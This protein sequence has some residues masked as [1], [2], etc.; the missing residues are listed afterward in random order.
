MLLLAPEKTGK[1]LA[2]LDALRG[3]AAALVVYEHAVSGLWPELHEASGAWFAAGWCGVMVFFLASGYIVPASLERRGDVRG[4]WIGRLFRLYPLWAVCVAAGLVLLPAEGSALSALAHLTMLQD[5]LGV[6]SVV[7]V[8]WTLSYEMAFYLLLT[9]LFALGLHRRSTALALGFTGCALAAGL[10]GL[11]GITWAAGAEAF[12]RGPV[13]VA[14]VVVVG[15]GLALVL[16]GRGRVRQAGAA[17]LALVVVALLGL[18]GRLPVW[19]SLLILATMF[20]GTVLCRVES[21]QIGRRAAWLMLLIPVAGFALSPGTNLK[22]AFV[23]A[24]VIFLGGMALRGRGMPYALAWLGT[25]S[26]SVYLL[27]PLLLAVLP[28]IWAVPAT[29]AV[30][31]LT[32]RLVE[33]PAQRLGKRLATAGT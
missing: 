33:A 16:A 30:S 31:A 11:A 25:V 14:A 8:L 7:S 21:G 6:S 22:S 18:G 5:L 24:W 15:A 19:Q 28:A 3:L 13:V 26:Y 23:A 17:V 32:W 1:R 12:Q 20:A 4:F 2:W 10:A 27:H 9:A 29:L